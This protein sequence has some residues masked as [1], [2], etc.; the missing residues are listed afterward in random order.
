MSEW[1][2]SS[3]RKVWSCQRRE[4]TDGNGRLARIFLNC[5]LFAPGQQRILIPTSKRENYL[6]ALRA[7]SR[8]RRPELLSRVMGDLQ[9]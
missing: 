7:L 8:R 5:E 9:G 4:V 1:R 3:D 2:R 6:I